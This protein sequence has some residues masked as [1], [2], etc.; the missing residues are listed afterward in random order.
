MVSG[1]FYPNL[2]IIL[3][4]YICHI[5]DILQLWWS[6]YYSNQPLWG[7]G[8]NLWWRR[9]RNPKKTEIESNKK[10][11]KVAGWDGCGANNTSSILHNFWRLSRRAVSRPTRW[12]LLLIFGLLCCNHLYIFISNPRQQRNIAHWCASARAHTPILSMHSSTFTSFWLL[13]GT[14]SHSGNSNGRWLE[15]ASF[16]KTHFFWNVSDEDDL[17]ISAFW[18][19]K[20]V[21]GSENLTAKFINHIWRNSHHCIF[22]PFLSQSLQ[23]YIYIFTHIYA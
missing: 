22:F 18:S 13:C 7:W 17:H 2:P 11:K 5:C 12:S 1:T 6:R 21:S 14:K 20:P 15:G 9:R 23:I 16:E 3:H 19:I 8:C 4:R 10:E